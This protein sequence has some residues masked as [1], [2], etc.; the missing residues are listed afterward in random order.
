LQISVIIPIYN[1]ANFLIKATQSALDQ[2]EVAEVVLVED[3]SP[4][5]ALEIAKE[6]AKSEDRVK[7]FQHPDKKNH[8]AG[9]S[10]N[11]GIEKSVCDYIAFL[12]ADDYY[13]PDRFKKTKSVFRKNPESEGVYEAIGI[14]FYIKKNMDSYLTR[15][16]GY[17]LTTIEEGIPADQLFSTFLLGKKGWWHLNGFTIK[18]S[19]LKKTGFFDPILKQTQD[20]DFILRACLTERL[21]AG[22]LDTPVAMRGVHNENRISNDVLREK[23]QRLF[24]SKWFKKMLSENWGKKINRFL[25]RIYMTTHP[26]IVTRIPSHGLARIPAKILLAIFLLLRYPRLLTK[27]I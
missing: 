9:A 13:L 26:L 22:Q 3:A 16:N 14:H 24:Y 11:L 27:I 10:R 5:N 12:D 21:S 17:L 20:T 6:L 1:A 2:P 4:D 25:L 23:Y 7:I 8:G 15:K 18:R 19:I